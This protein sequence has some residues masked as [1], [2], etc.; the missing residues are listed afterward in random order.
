MCGFA[1]WGR[2]GG[3]TLRL[4]HARN[5]REPFGNFRKLQRDCREPFGNFQKV[6]KVCREPCGAPASIKGNAG[7]LSGTPESIT[8]KA[9][10]PAC[11]AFQGPGHHGGFAL[12]TG[13]NTRRRAE[14]ARAAPLMTG[15]GPMR[16]GRWP[17]ALAY[18][19][20]SRSAFSLASTSRSPS[21]VPAA[22]LLM[23]GASFCLRLFA[24]EW[25]RGLMSSLPSSNVREW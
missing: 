7:S 5:G 20:L 16:I 8:G 14:T 12:S 9:A 3:R 18:L 2:F 19:F 1:V 21:E 10:S 13:K 4:C 23:T 15:S 22:T 11:G 6:Q 17:V 25:R 24:A